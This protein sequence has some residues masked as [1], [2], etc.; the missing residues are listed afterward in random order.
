[1]ENR[2]VNAYGFHSIGFVTTK[3]EADR[4]CNIE[5]IPKALYPWPLEYANEFEGES[6]PTFIA[7]KIEDISGFTIEQ[8]KDL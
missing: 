2:I 3:E 7:K 8:L 5:K 1:M 6:A 4:I